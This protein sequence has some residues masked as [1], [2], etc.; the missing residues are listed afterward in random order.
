[1]S[2]STP[3]FPVSILIHNGDLIT[4]AAGA[5]PPVASRLP[6]NYIAATSTA[7]GKVTGDLTS[8][9]NAKGELSPLTRTQQA[10]LNTLQHCMNQ[11]RQTAKLAF[12]GQTV[13]LHQEFQVGVAGPYDLGSFLARADIIIASVQNAAN[14]AALKLKGWTDADT[15]AFVAARQSLGT[16]N[17]TQQ[18]AKGGAKVTT[19]QKDAHAADLYERLADHSKRRRPAM[20][21]HRSRQCRRARRVL[22]QHLSALQRSWQ[23]PATTR[24]SARNHARAPS[25]N[26]SNSGIK[27]PVPK[28][29]GLS[30][31]GGRGRFFLITRI[32]NKGMADERR[33]G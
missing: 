20:A 3:H 31:K 33:P 23:R 8:Q 6:A 1:M 24:A 32:F 17:V 18:T 2:K 22:P 9:K 30:R 19:G 12:P 29:G 11:A 16:V 5:N 14:L 7:L 4:A 26:T 21:G 13:K 10:N 15:T 27:L 25:Q 28:P